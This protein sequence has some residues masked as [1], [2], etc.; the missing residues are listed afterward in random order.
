MPTWS[1]T[2]YRP[3]QGPGKSPEDVLKTGHGTESSGPEARSTGKEVE[4]ETASAHTPW[5]NQGEVRVDRKKVILHSGEPGDGENR[6]RLSR[7]NVQPF[8]LDVV[9]HGNRW[10]PTPFVGTWQECVTELIDRFGFT[11]LPYSPVAH[12]DLP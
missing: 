3:R 6:A 2:F 7:L 8:R 12:P 1:G 5:V 4:G 11:R 10:E 9:D